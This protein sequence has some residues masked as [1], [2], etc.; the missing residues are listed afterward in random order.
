[1]MVETGGGGK[2]IYFTYP[3]GIT[4]GA[5][6]GKDSLGLDYRGEGGFVMAP[7]SP[8]PTPEVTKQYEWEMQLGEYK[9]N[10]PPQW[11][12]DKIEDDKDRESSDVDELL[13]GVNEGRRNDSAT[14]VAGSLLAKFD[15]DNWNLAWE[16]LKAWNNQNTPPLPEE[17]LKRTFKSIADREK[18]K[19]RNEPFASGNIN[20]G[21]RNEWDGI[22]TA[23]RQGQKKRARYQSAN[24]LKEERDFA[25]LSGEDKLL[26]YKPSEGT[27]NDCGKEYIE[28]KVQQ[29]LTSDIT[30][31]DVSEIIG[32][33]KRSSHRRHENFGPDDPSLICLQNGV[34]DL[35]AGK[36]HPHSSDYEF[37]SCMPVKYDPKA[38]SDELDNFFNSTFRPQDVPLIE[39]IAGFCLYRDY[40]LRKAVMFVGE[41]GNGK[42]ITLQLMESL[43]G[44]GNV[45]GWTLQELE[46]NRFAKSNLYRKYANIAGDLPGRR[47]KDTGT[48]KQLTGRDHI[49]AD[50]KYAPKPIEFTNY[51]KL[52]FSTNNIPATPD[53]TEA[54]FDR[55]ILVEFP[56]KFVE[57]PT[58]ENEKEKD[59]E[60]L[61]K[62]T[63]EK[64]KSAFLNRAIEGLRRLLD[65]REFSF[66]KDTSQV[67]RQYERLSE[68]VKAFSEEHLIKDGSSFVEKEKVYEAY[69][70]YCEENDLSVRAKSVFSRKLGK[71]IDVTGSQHRINGERKRCYEGV[72]LKQ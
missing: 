25:V 57:E 48:F 58:E 51:A 12:L 44:S 54:F 46:S 71:F 3:D 50:I 55:W 66:D 7:P 64:A 19:K 14:K 31:H 8:Y 22:S 47:L 6:I 33:V 68:P 27:F 63:T 1:P 37:R 35:E 42:T 20:R 30:S 53:D 29:E 9:P 67:R 49:T 62:I 60:I 41:G 13:D 36:L 5:R 28:S 59:P 39:E 69:Q 4:I 10:D 16:G 72:D 24:K 15:E 40:F 17:E 61:A 70:E 34:F 43:L 65:N 56:Y 26:T 2:H 32:H 11:L 21:K 18:R 52:L 45:T 38:S 23:F